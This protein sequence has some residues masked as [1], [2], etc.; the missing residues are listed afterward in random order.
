MNR[1]MG[2]NR[3]HF[4]DAGKLK[5]DR[6]HFPNFNLQSHISRALMVLFFL[7]LATVALPAADVSSD[8]ESANKLY[9]QGRYSEAVN[10]YDK[11]LEGGNVSESLYFNRGNAFFKLGQ[12]GRAIASYRQ[13]QQLAPRDRD[14]RANLQLAR[15][16]ARGGS[17][18][19]GD[20]WR[21]WLGSVSLNEW[22]L[23]SV[24]ALW[25]FFI[26]LAVKQ[27]RPAFSGSLRNFIM[28][29]ASAAACF[30]L[31]LGVTLN[32]DYLRSSAIVIVGE[33][34]VRN[35]PLEESPSIFKVRD[36]AELDVTD[37]KDGWLQV[38]DPA[39]RIGWVHE[40]QV[41]LFDPATRPPD[42][43]IHI[44]N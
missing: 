31:C 10:A 24:A 41:L 34:D 44:H 29:S 21:Y 20:Q 23:L 40:S 19:H 37:K 1:E 5:P 27:W 16:R 2:R 4:G 33:A 39:Q 11:L 8:F 9:E 32:V 26:L 22:T 28:A 13:A 25:A 38:V 7:L 30:G 43:M 3:L 35:G 42:S 12:I 15:T 18:Y 17:P 36:G 6:M 14:L